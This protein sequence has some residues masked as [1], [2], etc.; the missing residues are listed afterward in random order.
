MPIK[1]HVDLPEPHDSGR[2]PAPKSD[3]LTFGLGA[4]IRSVRQRRGMTQEALADAVGVVRTSITN[5]ERG[6]QSLPMDK[7]LKLAAAL[8]MDVSLSLTPR[9]RK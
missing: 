5:L 1:L 4:V 9:P 6:K 3:D 7:L 8:G 2:A